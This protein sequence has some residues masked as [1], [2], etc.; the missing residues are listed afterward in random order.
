M[1]NQTAIS[2]PNPSTQN[3]EKDRSAVEVQTIEGEG[4][5]TNQLID[6]KVSVGKSRPEEVM[7]EDSDEQ[8]IASDSEQGAEVGDTDFPHAYFFLRYM[9]NRENCWGTLA[10]SPPSDDAP[11][12]ILG[13]NV[14]GNLKNDEDQGFTIFVP[15]ISNCQTSFAPEDRLLL[16]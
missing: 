4:N 6:G 13:S 9:C 11:S 8:M 10:P 5:L 12:K 7:D 2:S 1:S 15:L 3:P 14:C 16:P